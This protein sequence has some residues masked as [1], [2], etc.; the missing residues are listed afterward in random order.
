[1]QIVDLAEQ[2][3]LLGQVARTLETL[4]EEVERVREEE[5]LAPIDQ[6]APPVLRL[7]ELAI[8]CT[9]QLHDL[10][11]SQYAAMTYGRENVAHL[12]EACAQVSLA[13][14]LCTIAI[15]S[16]TEILLYGGADPTPSTSRNHLRRA[17]VEMDRAATTYQA[18]AQRL[19][20]RLASAAVR[21]EDQQHIDRSLAAPVAAHPST[22]IA[23]PPLTIPPSTPPPPA[24]AS[25]P[26]ARH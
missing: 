24:T 12:A 13:S 19:S 25:T 26:H 11:S 21:N 15:S 3:R 17:C 5:I 6:L 8:T 1:M 9:R 18:L 4:T 2:T 23:G 16:R 22:V 10:S 14:A 7:H 20:R